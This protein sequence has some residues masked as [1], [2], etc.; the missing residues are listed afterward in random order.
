MK[1]AARDV[2]HVYPHDSSIAHKMR[3]KAIEYIL[4]LSPSVKKSV[5]L[6]NF[7]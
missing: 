3:E 6:R 1:K 7:I 4:K 2:V 5:N